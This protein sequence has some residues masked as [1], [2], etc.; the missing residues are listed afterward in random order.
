MLKEANAE[1][2][3][4]NLNIHQKILKI[5]EAAGVLQRTKEGYGYKY[6][7][8][9]EIQAKVT[10]AMQKY[11]VMLYCQIQPGTLNITSHSYERV[12]YVQIRKERDGQKAEYERQSTP[13]NEVIVS[14][15]ALYT[16]INT[17]NPDEKI[18]VP[19]IIIGQMED[20]SQAFGAA[21]TYCNRYFL[22]KTL[23]LATTESDPDNYRS[24]QKESADYE[25]IKVAQEKQEAL[26]TKIKE[27]VDAGAKLI[28]IGVSRDEMYSIV[29]KHNEGRKDPATINDVKVCE[30]I[31]VEFNKIR[32]KIDE[33]GGEGVRTKSTSK[34]STTPNSEKS[35][36]VR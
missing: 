27:V 30:D 33:K 12:K 25:D 1:T 16:W 23:Q 34:K 26:R 8:E 36:E 10:G 31:L 6:V 32:L 9:E 24:K 29:E 35:G 15:E 5:A 13:V 22:M 3:S 14:A 11:G 21:C 18:E 20:A 4:G 19:W 2:K 7:P 17:D 28:S